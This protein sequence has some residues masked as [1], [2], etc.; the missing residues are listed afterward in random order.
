MYGTAVYLAFDLQSLDLMG[1]AMEIPSYFNIPLIV[2][3][4]LLWVVIP[5]SLS[6][7]WF[8]KKEI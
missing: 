5:I 2:G 6:L 4:Q 3:V 1:F 8:N 7:Y